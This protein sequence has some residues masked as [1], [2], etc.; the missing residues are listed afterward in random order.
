MLTKLRDQINVLSKG[1]YFWADVARFR[2]AFFSITHYLRDFSEG[3]Y[4]QMRN[5]ILSDLVIMAQVEFLG[6][7]ARPPFFCIFMLTKLRDQINVLSKGTYFWADVA[8]FRGAFF[9]ITHYL[10]DFS[11]GKYIKMR[12]VILSDLVIMAQVEFFGFIVF[13]K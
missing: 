9:S 5:V 4:I 11:E 10:L 8:R 2:G 12:N 13:L 7:F 3:K 1:T 6:F